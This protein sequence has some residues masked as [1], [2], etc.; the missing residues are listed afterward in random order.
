MTFYMCPIFL[1]LTAGIILSSGIKNLNFTWD[2]HSQ[3]CV[4]MEKIRKLHSNES[5]ERAENYRSADDCSLFL[6]HRLSTRAAASDT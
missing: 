6:A 3:V 4:R 2:A 1:H 5:L